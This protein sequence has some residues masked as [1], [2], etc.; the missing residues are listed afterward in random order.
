MS[1]VCLSRHTPLAGPNRTEADTHLVD[2]GL[3]HGQTCKEILSFVECTMK[4]WSNFQHGNPLLFLNFVGFF[5]VFSQY[6]SATPGG[7]L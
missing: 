6:L 3:E 7:S 4:L 1:R 2:H 5:F